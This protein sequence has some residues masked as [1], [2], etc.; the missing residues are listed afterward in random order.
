MDLH[1]TLTARRTELTKEAESLLQQLRENELRQDEVNHI[2]WG[3]GTSGDGTPIPADIEQPL[4]GAVNQ[5]EWILNL[6]RAN[7]HGLT[8]KQI[9]T[10]LAPRIQSRARNRRKV[11]SSALSAL[12]KEGRVVLG[13]GLYRLPLQLRGSG[14]SRAAFSRPAEIKP[15]LTGAVNHSEWI[16][17]LLQANPE[18]LTSKQV[19][20]YLDPMI[21]STSLNRRSVLSSALSALKNE[22]RVVLTEGVYRL[23]GR[24]GDLHPS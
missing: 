24:A 14:S 6:L 20:T 8:S 18:G 17:N 1:T 12:R 10:Y 16:L 21:Q 7:S 15:P 19:V 5:F 4:P 3:F 9:T 11:L 2:L 22:G 23:A 13:H